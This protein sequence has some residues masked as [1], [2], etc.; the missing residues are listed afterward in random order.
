MKYQAV[1]FDLFG[2]L[3][4]NFG[5]GYSYELESEGVLA[6]L[7]DFSAEQ[8]RA[9]WIEKD[10]MRLRIT[11]GHPNLSKHIR[12]VCGQLSSTPSEA[13]IGRAV[14][15]RI[16]HYKDAF[17][18]R[19]GTVETL[20]AIKSSGQ[21]IGL[22]TACS[23]EA[24][25]LW[26]DN[27]MRKYFDATVFSCCVGATKP[28]P[29]LFEL[30]CERLAVAPGKCLYVGD[31]DGEELTGATKFGMDAVHICMDHERELIM[32]R[33]EAANWAGRR[34]TNLSGVLDIICEHNGR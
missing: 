34:I 19:P 11:G 4:D 31:G 28:D 6:E 10:I 32:K 26:P 24:P 12:Y 25:L 7:G 17:I 27:P 9:K 23:Y 22:I 15:I 16:S 5:G 18:P 3:V 13:A 20:A 21:K 8:F 2:T 1:I 29:R 30:A 33:P 14:E